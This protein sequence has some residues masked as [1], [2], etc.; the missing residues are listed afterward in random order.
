[1]KRNFGSLTSIAG[2]VCQDAPVSAQGVIDV[3]NK[4][5]AICMQAIV[6][7]VPAIFATEFFIGSAFY[8]GAAISTKLLLERDR[9]HRVNFMDRK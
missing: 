4:V 1:M 8:F 7:T 6:I 5:V 3:A 2:Q 9:F